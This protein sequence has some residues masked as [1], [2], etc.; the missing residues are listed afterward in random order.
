[1][2]HPKDLKDAIHRMI[3]NIS[4]YNLLVKIYTFIKYLR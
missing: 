1:M 4:D 2:N 3:D